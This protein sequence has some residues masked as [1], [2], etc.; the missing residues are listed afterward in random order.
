MNRCDALGDQRLL[1]RTCHVTAQRERGD[2]E[3]GAL[4]L[5]IIIDHSRVQARYALL[6]YR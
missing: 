3:K 4:V 5:S 1:H 2:G 6:S